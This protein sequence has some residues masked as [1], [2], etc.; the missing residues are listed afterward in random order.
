M[1]LE[2]SVEEKIKELDEFIITNP[3][4]REFKRALAVKLALQGWKYEAIA[5]VLV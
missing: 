2:H 1:D 5:K 3:D 4:V